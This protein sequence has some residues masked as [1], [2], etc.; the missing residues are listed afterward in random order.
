[1]KLHDVMRTLFILILSLTACQSSDTIESEELQSSKQKCLIIL[2]RKGM[3][4][5]YPQDAL[6]EWANVARSCTEQHSA[7]SL[8]NFLLDKAVNADQGSYGIQPNDDDGDEPIIRIRKKS[9]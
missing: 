8:Y 5:L 2:Q 9:S 3:K 1:M 7:D 6:N 4:N